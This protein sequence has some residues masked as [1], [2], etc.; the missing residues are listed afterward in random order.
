MA[1]TDYRETVKRILLEY[2]AFKPSYGEVEVEAVFDEERGHYEVCYAGWEESRRIHGPI[3]H[4]DIRGDKVWIQHDG[5]E[6]GIADEL[7]AGG[8]PQEH[9]VLAFHHPRKRK[10]TGFAIS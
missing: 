5:T 7:V 4:V 6:T 3:L 2:A 10:Y 9:I 8:I 1:G